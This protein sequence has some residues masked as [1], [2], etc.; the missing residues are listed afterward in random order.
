MGSVAIRPICH[1]CEREDPYSRAA[2]TKVNKRFFGIWIP[3]K[4]T[5]RAFWND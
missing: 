1:P 5:E 3:D 4:R 2:K